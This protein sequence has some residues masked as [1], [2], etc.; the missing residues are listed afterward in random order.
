MKLE[1]IPEINAPVV[2]IQTMYP[3]ASP[4]EV[5][6]KITEPI[7]QRISNLD[8]VDVVSSSSFSSVSLIQ[9]QYNFDKDMDKAEEEAKEAVADL[10]LPEGVN[11]PSVSRLRIDAFPVMSLAVVDGKA[12]RDE[13]T[14]MVEEKVV[15]ALEGVDGVSSV[16]IAGQQ[17]KKVHIEY[18]QEQL[19]KYGLD[20]RTVNEIIKASAGN[21]S[22]GLFQFGNSEKVVELNGEIH[23]LTELKGL[24]VPAIPSGD[25]AATPQPGGGKASAPMFAGGKAP[26][27][28]PTIQLQDIADIKEVSE[29]ESV[30]RTNGKESIGI[31]IVKDPEANTVDVV[32]GV[33]E[34]ISQ[35]KDKIDGL[36]IFT[37]FDQGKP[38]EKSVSTMLNKALVGAGFAFLII[39]LFLRNVRTTLISVVS[40]PLSLVMALLILK[41]MDIT[42][43][44]MTLGAMTVAIGRVVDDS[45]VVIENIFR[46]MTLRGEML[47]GKELVQEATREMFKPILSS[48]VVTGAVFLPLGL[49]D[50]P[51]GE[52]FL[53]FALTVVFALAASL[54][55]AITVVP[56]LAHALLK[57]DLDQ[58]TP[59]TGEDHKD[60]PGRLA[61]MYKQI[62]NWSLNHKVLSFGLAIVLLVSSLGLVPVVGVSFL[63][64]DEEKMIVVT[65]DPEPGQTRKGI[66]DIAQSIEDYFQ[67][68]TGVD[69]IQY[70]VGGKNPMRPGKTNQVMFFVKYKEDY[71]NFAAEKDK[72]M[73]DLKERKDP[74]TWESQEAASST[75]NNNQLQ[76]NVYGESMAQLRTAV[77]DIMNTAEKTGSVQHIDSSLS[78]SY[79]QYTLLPNREKLSQYG[80]TA[81]QIAMALSHVGENPALITLKN[82]DKETSVYVEVEK[83]HYNT[84]SDLEKTKI[85][86]PLGLEI[87]LADVVDIKEEKAADTITRRDGK[88]SASITMDAKGNDVSRVSAELQKEID[89]L[90]LPAGVSVEYSGVTEQIKESFTQLGLAM[91]AAIAIV[92]LILVITFGGGLAP[93]AILFSLP[94]TII[95]GL[96]GLWVTG[97]TIS[98]STLIGALMLIGIVV[99]NAI[100]L[101]DRVIQKEKH[102][103]STRE[104]LLEAG[105][106]RLRPILMTAIATVGALLPLAFGLEGS[107][108]I[109]KGLAVTVIGGLTSSTL[110]TLVI[111]PVV[112]EWVLGARSKK[113]AELKS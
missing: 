38:I 11:T 28:V 60:Q 78:E 13:L 67:K 93:F 113:R 95:G 61:E 102:G 40:I 64:S 103:L 107:G 88:I 75:G 108:L 80:L 6:R 97:E 10:H 29:A 9:V 104:A 52:L 49:V 44:I 96:M 90:Q 89:S 4:N 16:Q 77:K 55:V 34:E 85:Q 92:Y 33:K 63:P 39:L 18:K 31:Q 53:P 46:R 22:L 69:V 21:Y 71:E 81:G 91:L 59:D 7:E 32:N 100:V 79:D 51:V 20:E 42:L 109:S 83:K 27:G 17:V 45:I 30:S 72:V 19:K 8:G 58:K 43:N 106:T 62:L 14:R 15:P 57:K 74:G 1:M 41:Q 47:K 73:K 36:E 82:D 101:V 68:R 87:S 50:G 5:A 99:T 2:T 84:R 76:V 65:F 26:V 66:E 54:I 3:G 98:V 24:K 70:S 111:V 112:Y 86:T 37:V 56:M 94:F 35:L 23:S 25:G 110:L 48:T 12:S 105:V